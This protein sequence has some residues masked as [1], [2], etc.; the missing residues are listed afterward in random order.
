VS[1]DSYSV[2]TSIKQ[3]NKFFKKSYIPRG[4]VPSDLEDRLFQ[5]L[6]GALGPSPHP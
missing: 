6:L 2:F 4:S 5:E 3:I 1:E